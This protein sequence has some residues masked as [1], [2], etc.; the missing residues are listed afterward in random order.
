MSGRARIQIRAFLMSELSPAALWNLL[1]FL[2]FLSDDSTLSRGEEQC[3]LPQ[4]SCSRWER[5]L[6]QQ[7]WGRRW[8]AEISSLGNHEMALFLPPG[9]ASHLRGSAVLT[10]PSLLLPRSPTPCGP[11]SGLRWV[12]SSVEHDC[13]GMD[14]NPFLYLLNKVCYMI[15]IA[16]RTG[17]L[18]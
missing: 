7:G 6:E 4:N 10:P 13:G 16:K 8:W 14:S 2:C 12:P 9:P 3:L 18:S 5:P 11:C 17:H 1:A 15:F